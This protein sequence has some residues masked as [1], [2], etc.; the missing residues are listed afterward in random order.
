VQ[1]HKTLWPC[2]LFALQELVMLGSVSY[3]F[4]E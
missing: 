2:L 3:T 1:I 4:L